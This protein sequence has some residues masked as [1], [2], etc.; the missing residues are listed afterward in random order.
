MALNEGS[1]VQVA[2]LTDFS[3]AWSDF[4]NTRSENLKTLAPEPPIEALRQLFDS[5]YS[6][7]SSASPTTVTDSPTTIADSPT[8]VTATP[9]TLTDSSS[10]SSPSAN[11]NA[12]KALADISSSGDDSSSAQLVSLAEK[13]GPVVLGLLAGNVLIGVALVAIGLVMCM[14][15][16]T[17]KTRSVSP[18][19]APVRFKEADSGLDGNY[20]D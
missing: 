2:P 6:A 8:T 20:H 12:F 3:D 1:F 11:G 13:Y 9:I 15:R 10:S 19:Y 16:G 14:R 4:L 7:S 17:G 18:T 5:S